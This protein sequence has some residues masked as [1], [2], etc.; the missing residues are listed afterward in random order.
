V[1]LWN[2]WWQRGKGQGGLPVEYQI[3]LL[4]RL[5]TMIVAK[6]VASAMNVPTRPKEMEMAS[7]EDTREDVSSPVCCRW[8]PEPYAL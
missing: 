1:L 5:R 4:L 8:M 6:I 3:N 7:P 2:E